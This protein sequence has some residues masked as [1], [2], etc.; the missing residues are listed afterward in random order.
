M[1]PNHIVDFYP[2][3]ELIVNQMLHNGVT[4]ARSLTPLQHAGRICS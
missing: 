2:M 3:R 1:I 4:A